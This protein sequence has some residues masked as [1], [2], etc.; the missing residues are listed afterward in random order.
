M[1]FRDRFL[2][3][4]TAEAITSPSAIVLAGAGT[5]VAIVA[6]API[7]A[8]AGAGAAVYAGWVAL[9]MPK[10]QPR[11]ADDIDP[12]RLRDPWRRYV[13][14][15]MEAKERYERALAGAGTGPL[16]A[17]LDEI[18]DRVDDG[19]AECWRIANRGQ[20]FEDALGQLVPEAQVTERIRTLE[21]APSTLTNDRMIAALREQAATYRRIRSTAE[22]ASQRLQILD[23]RLDEIVARAV[24]L[25][26]QADDPAVLGGLGEDVDALVI[27]MEALRRGLDETAGQTAVG[28]Q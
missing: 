25:G 24:E 21:A 18:G 22:Q 12:R 20:Q 10:A 8:A 5:A 16:R 17:R 26:L 4:Q 23:V 19:I 11:P 15:A 13:Q 9:R 6:G 14:E 1:S 27:D 7:V 2:T 28:R 3:R